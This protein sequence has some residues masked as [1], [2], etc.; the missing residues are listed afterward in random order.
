MSLVNTIFVPK[1]VLGDNNKKYIIVELPTP[2][3]FQHKIRW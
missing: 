3:P 1:N 2:R